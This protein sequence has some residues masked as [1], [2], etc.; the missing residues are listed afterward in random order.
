MKLVY[1]N[2]HNPVRNGDRVSNFDANV[3]D[4]REPHKPNSTGRVV[5]RTDEGLI[6]EFF[7]NVIGAIWIDR[8]D[9]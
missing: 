1:E 3:I 4:I 6:R 9:Q 2:S 8:T 5:L 7:P